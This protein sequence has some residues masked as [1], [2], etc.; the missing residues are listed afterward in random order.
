[1][2]PSASRT[3]RAIRA[4][5]WSPTRSQTRALRASR[6]SLTNWAASGAGSPARSTSRAASRTLASSWRTAR[7]SR[8]CSWRT[9]P[10]SSAKSRSRRLRLPRYR[11]R[12]AAGPCPTP[13]PAPPGAPAA[14]GE[15]LRA[16]LLAAR[17]SHRPRRGAATG[18]G[19]GPTSRR[20][21]AGKAAGRRPVAPWRGGLAVIHSEFIDPCVPG[22]APQRFVFRTRKVP[23]PTGPGAPRGWGRGEGKGARGVGKLRAPGPVLA[24]AWRGCTGRCSA[25]APWRCPP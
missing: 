6:S 12:A 22:P 5:A 13:S 24:A 21:K 20:P 7:R 25:G 8:P 10:S 17:A 9:T 1:M 23:S 3:G 19:P 14:P 18:A 11:L 15:L 16:A 4:S 2:L